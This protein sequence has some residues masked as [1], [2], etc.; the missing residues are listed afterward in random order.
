[1][2]E[3]S[4]FSEKASALAEATPDA[5]QTCFLFFSGAACFIAI[6]FTFHT[7]AP[8]D[9]Y[10]LYSLLLLAGIFCGALT[11]T[12]NVGNPFRKIALAPALFFSFCLALGSYRL[13]HF[14]VW[15]HE[16]RQA[17]A[18]LGYG[19]SIVR[20]AAFT[21]TPL[22][23]YFTAL[24]IS[25][26]GMTE[27]GLRLFPC[28]F[29]AG[30]AWLFLELLGKLRITSIVKWV[31][32]FTYALNPWMI[33]YAQE[34]RPYSCALFCGML[35]AHA[36]L[37]FLHPPK[38]SAPRPWLA[39]FT[40]TLLFFLSIGFQ[41]LIMVAACSAAA[42][43][44]LF[45]GGSARKAWQLLAA[46]ALA[47]VLLAPL[48]YLMQSI[49]KAFLNDTLPFAE[50][51]ISGRG[52]LK[53]YAHA[54]DLLSW[55]LFLLP[56]CALLA[57]LPGPARARRF[58]PA[59]GYVLEFALLSGLL[60]VALFWLSFTLLV[61]FPL[62]SRYYLLAYPLALT[63][64]ALSVDPLIL[65][66][67]AATPKGLALWCVRGAFALLLLLPEAWQ[68]PALY[69]EGA[70]MRSNVDARALFQF[71][72]DRGA[73]GDLAYVI[74]FNEP[75]QWEQVGFLGAEFY[76]PKKQPVKLT[77]L[78]AQHGALSVTDL[79]LADLQQPPPRHIFIMLSPSWGLSAGQ[80]AYFEAIPEVTIFKAQGLLL[81]QVPVRGTFTAAL[82]GF[83]R[84]LIMAPNEQGRGYRAF[85]I[86]LALAEREGN[87][88]KCSTYLRGLQS[89][90]GN[91][92]KLVGL[93]SKH[94][95]KCAALLSRS[96]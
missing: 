39:L 57:C 47:L 44:F 52:L 15:L 64:L 30:S 56:S 68:L 75:S 82:E 14:S 42:A 58:R 33:R 32:A 74:P 79:I 13:S 12:P 71:L 20:R 17:A 85:D 66:L 51:E 91:Q 27:I 9:G 43:L 41:P 49:S 28:F 84:Q 25:L 8:L 31:F 22:S 48:L 45:I 16:E 29:Y 59:Q 93:K 2:K 78:W 72:R 70:F 21:Q 89:L 87:A 77:S 54:R 38:P 94:E 24:N 62:S 26:A 83:L 53:L 46:P 95:K 61:R 50:L 76:Y 55:L 35:W 7:P 60:F 90:P 96:N 69:F 4:N 81:F 23:Y 11:A 88:G 92:E 73:P 18:A 86:L 40:A 1:M 5:V 67:S 34:G 36:F 65:I 19:L 63:A 37:G 80:W 3:T 6:F 10:A